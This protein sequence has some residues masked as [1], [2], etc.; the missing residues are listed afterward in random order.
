MKK[1]V[2]IVIAVIL[3]LVVAGISFFY[4][5]KDVRN[6]SLLLLN[7]E[8]ISNVTKPA[9]VTIYH[10]IEGKASIPF[11]DIDWNK[12]D[13]VFPTTRKPVVLPINDDLRGS[14]FIVSSDGY[15]VTN[16]HVASNLSYK[17]IIAQQL[18]SDR[19]LTALNS[20][21]ESQQIDAVI[22]AKG[23]KDADL[24]QFGQDLA[25]TLGAKLAD[26]ITLTAD[27]KIVVL[28]PSSTETK[29]SDL[30]SNGFPATIV[31]VNENYID[32][33]KDIAILKIEGTNF[34]TIDLNA[35][36]T[37]NIGDKIYVSGFPSSA[38]FNTAD[39]LEATLTEGTVSGLK[40]SKTK[41]FKV[42][43]TDAKVSPGSSGGPL[44]NEQ[45]EVAGILTFASSAT[46][47]GDAFAFAIPASLAKEMLDSKNIVIKKSDWSL[48][49]KN[50]ISYL[51]N[52]QCKKAVVDF[53]NAEKESTNAAANKNTQAYI[54]ACN[55]IIASGKS[56]D[57][58]F[59][60]F[61]M[62]LSSLGSIYWTLAGFGIIFFIIIIF[63]IVKLLRR[64]R[65]DEKEI[66]DMESGDFT[67]YH[68]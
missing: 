26:K 15:V 10:H 17:R 58:A 59:D 2:S 11:F 25:L 32:D 40:D 34:P 23:I 49:L 29:L 48:S 22:K 38:Q 65:K 39:I 8:D 33:E 51:Q 50:G 53:E 20:A 4:F 45:G 54:S 14:G 18:I 7:Q 56:V 63:V 42:I 21:T 68:K 44:L 27:Q 55:A 31:N 1:R 66:R 30:I 13:I 67:R 60:V 24:E 62:R 19:F 61:K 43:Q 47:A 28:N 35:S 52:N 5:N 3:V 64:L 37:V 12:L 57:T 41:V 46:T 9:V 36:K 6:N 16:A